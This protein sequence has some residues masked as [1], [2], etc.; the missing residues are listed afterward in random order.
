MPSAGKLRTVISLHVIWAFCP[1][2]GMQVICVSH[3]SRENTALRACLAPANISVIP[4][5]QYPM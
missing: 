3:T 2:C 1:P 5:G 4:N